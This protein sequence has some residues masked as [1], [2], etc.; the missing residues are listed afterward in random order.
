MYLIFLLIPFLLGCSHEARI[1]SLERDVR[2]LKEKLSELEAD[3]ALFQS[4]P[5][6]RWVYPRKA[7]VEK[8]EQ[9]NERR[10]KK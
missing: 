4:T 8:K 9:K 6:G 3:W 10:A 7:P 2:G 1:S 5:D